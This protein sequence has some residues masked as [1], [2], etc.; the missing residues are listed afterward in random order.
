[1]SS[2][3]EIWSQIDHALATASLRLKENRLEK[4]A[5]KALQTVIKRRQQG[6]FVGPS[7]YEILPIVRRYLE[8][9][10]GATYEVYQETWIQQG[11][12]VTPEF[13]RAVSLNAI[14]CGVTE[15]VEKCLPLL[16]NLISRFSISASL[17]EV[18]EYLRSEGRRIQDDY[19]SRLEV[20]AKKME[21]AIE[22]AQAQPVAKSRRGRK[23]G[24]RLER[25]KNRER[26]V[27]EVYADLFSLEI[28]KPSTRQIV[29]ELAKRQD[30]S[31]P[32]RW[33]ITSWKR[34]LFSPQ[35]LR[36]AT[37]L[38]SKIKNK[39]DIRSVPANIPKATPSTRSKN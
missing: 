9:Y 26:A 22:R 15:Q 6:G 31:F 32:P 20:S 33:G 11:G 25:T 17:A 23:P 1:V 38:I 3:E 21:Y 12:E 29:D 19:R 4:L 16:E 18:S 30:K 13:L 7:I 2:I 24:Q 36:R 34:V 10:A 14:D 28:L 27:Q 39:G 35:L 8:S 5:V 37:K